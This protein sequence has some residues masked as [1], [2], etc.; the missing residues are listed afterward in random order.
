MPAFYRTGEFI[1]LI[2]LNDVIVINDAMRRKRKLLVDWS[3][4]LVPLVANRRLLC[5]EG[6]KCDVNSAHS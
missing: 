4:V 2:E 1:E 5:T 3:S 6:S